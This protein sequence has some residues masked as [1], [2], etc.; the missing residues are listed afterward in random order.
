MPTFNKTRWQKSGTSRNFSWRSCT[1][2]AAMDLQSFVYV[3]GIICQ[4]VFKPQQEVPSTSTFKEELMIQLDGWLTI[5]IIVGISLKDFSDLFNM[6]YV[7][8]YTTLPPWIEAFLF[9]KT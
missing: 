7:G 3:I 2:F 4:I 6:E 1:N 5:L 8:S 9:E